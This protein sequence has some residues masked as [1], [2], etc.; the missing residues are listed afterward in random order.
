MREGTLNAGRDLTLTVT[1]QTRF[2]RDLA[3]CINPTSGVAE[4]RCTVQCC[5]VAADFF[6]TV[7]V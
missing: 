3:F 1:G 7:T 4:K 6:D 5:L 2:R